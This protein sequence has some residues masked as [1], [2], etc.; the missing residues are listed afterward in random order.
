M[1]IQDSKILLQNAL[2]KLQKDLR[3]FATNVEDILDPTKLADVVNDNS[4]TENQKNCICYH[5]MGD[6]DIEGVPEDLNSLDRNTASDIIS[7][8]KKG[9]DDI[10]IAQL[11]HLG[12]IK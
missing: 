2:D 6:D 11:K 9:N 10:A 4:I 1:A 5:L 3:E 12:C 7:S 8:F